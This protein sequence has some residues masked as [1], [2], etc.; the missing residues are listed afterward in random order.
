MILMRALFDANVLMD[1]LMRRGGWRSSLALIQKVRNGKIEGYISALT[2]EIIYFLRARSLPEAESK[3][4]TKRII[5]GFKIASLTEDVVK[6]AL[7]EERIEDIEDAVQFH[8]AKEVAE[9]FITRNKKDFSTV[10]DEI[11]ILTPE[12]FLEKYEP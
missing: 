1:V 12:E 9:I 8:S 2:V 11:E 5:R 3:E 4:V 6:R 10:K 7:D